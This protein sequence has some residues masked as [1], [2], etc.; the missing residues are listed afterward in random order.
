MGSIGRNLH[1]IAVA[2][3]LQSRL[4]SSGD[5]LLS[6]RLARVAPRITGASVMTSGGQIANNSR[7]LFGGIFFECELI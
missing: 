3:A 2:V 1:L 5:T 7:L 4:A 6:C